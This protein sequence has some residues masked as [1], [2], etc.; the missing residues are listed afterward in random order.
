M[1]DATIDNEIAVNKH[2]LIRCTGGKCAGAQAL[3][4]DAEVFG[5]QACFGAVDGKGSAIQ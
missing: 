5:V 2:S 1:G 4:V 3:A